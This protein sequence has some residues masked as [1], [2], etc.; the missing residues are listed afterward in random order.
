MCGDNSVVHACIYL[1]HVMPVD[2]HYLEK[3]AD[4]LQIIK[5]QN[6]FLMTHAHSRVNSTCQRYQ[7]TWNCT[8]T[9]CK[10]VCSMNLSELH[11]RLRL[12]D[13]TKMWTWITIIRTAGCH[14]MW[15]F[16][17][18]KNAHWLIGS[19]YIKF[20]HRTWNFIQQCYPAGC[21]GNIYFLL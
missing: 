6:F 19:E 17:I 1:D 8:A 10:K 3:C 12:H 7:S 5:M 14:K 11:W 4:I 20:K 9:S 13:K 18:Q 16:K 21:L 15:R 2:K